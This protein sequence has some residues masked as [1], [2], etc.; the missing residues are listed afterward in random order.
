MFPE[1]KTFI[2]KAGNFPSFKHEYVQG[3]MPSLMMMDLDGTV[4]ETLGIGEWKEQAIVDYLN[5]R[6]DKKVTKLEAWGD[7]CQDDHEHCEDWAKNGECENNPE[8]MKDGCK[9]S[10]GICTPAVEGGSNGEAATT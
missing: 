4:K 5:G 7:D 3:A 9:K 1:I 10:C 2:D 6:L 8:Y